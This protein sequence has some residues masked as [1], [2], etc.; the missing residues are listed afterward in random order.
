MGAW[1]EILRPDDSQ[2]ATLYL[3]AKTKKRVLTPKSQ[4][5]F[6]AKDT[7]EI[8]WRAFECRNPNCPA[9]AVNPDLFLFITPDPAVYIKPDGTL[10][11]DEGK[12]NGA[13]QQ[14]T[15]G[16]CPECLKIRNLESESSATRERYASY[17][18]PH[19]LPE[20]AKRLKELDEEYKRRVEWEKKK[21]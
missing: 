3:N 7:G 9:K 17:V 13:I 6:V 4:V 5:N 10:G 2:S 18:Q 8:C 12:A 15:T 1:Q 14:E 20:T 11:F 19:V 16:S 21:K